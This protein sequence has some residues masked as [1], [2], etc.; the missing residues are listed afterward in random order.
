MLLSRWLAL[1]LLT[2]VW[3]SPA[4]ADGVERRVP[5]GGDL[6]QALNAAQAGDRIVLEPGATYL[7]NFVLPVHSGSDFVT[8]TTDPA[9]S[10]LPPTGKR[11][12]PE[13]AGLLAKIQSPNGE[14]ALATAPGARHWRLQF[15]EFPGGRSSDV[16]LLGDGGPKQRTLADVP[17]DLVIDRCYIH[18]DANG[19]GPKRGVALN[20]GR[21][22]IIGST[23]ADFARRGQ[24]TQAIGGW[25]GPGPYLI[26]NNRLEAAAENF[27][28]G[29][30]MP[31]IDGL[32]PSD[33]T[34]RHNYVTKPLAWRNQKLNVKNLFELKNA[35]RVLVEFNVFEN[36]WADA[37]AGYAIVLTPRGESGRAPWATVEDVTFRYNIVRHAGGGVNVLGRDDGGASGQLRG[38]RISNN[39]FYDISE[40]NWGGAGAFV[41]LGDEPATVVIEHNT[42]LHTGTVV[43]AYG[44]TKQSA[45]PIRGF[46]F[47]DNLARHNRYGVH[48]GGR[49]VGN[50]TLQWYFPGAIFDNNVLAGAKASLYPPDNLFPSVEEFERQFMSLATDDFRLV[51]ESSFRGKATDGVDLGADISRI[52]NGVPADDERRPDRERRPVRKGPG[53]VSLGAA[54]A[55]ASFTLARTLVRP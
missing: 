36:T 27:L 31:R 30:A 52:A 44:G 10:D 22:T 5:A 6:Q 33:I 49:A 24:D 29:G 42:V 18:G 25:N 53:S 40:A 3:V 41:Q 23:I 2:S 28:L 11:I 9:S 1:I 13:H 45:A 12:S 43:V 7:G 14:A 38:L 17:G 35:R 26:E 34:F 16:I 50:D 47:R 15:L 46:I 21:T 54:L 51:P 4:A 8:L 39:L 32:V 20:S 55:V 19:A 48:G 37:Q